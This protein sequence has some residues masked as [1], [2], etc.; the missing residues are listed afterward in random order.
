[1]RK[2]ADI[3]LVER[4]LAPSREKARALIK[5]GAVSLDNV[6]VS[7]PGQLIAPNASLTITGD[8]LRWAS[9]GALK[10]LAALEAF[11]QIDIKGRIAADIGASTGGFCDVL[12]SRNV[13][14]IY[15]V[16]VGHG[17]L[18]PKLA[19]HARITNLERTNARDITAT[20]IPDPLQ[21]ITCDVSFISVQKALPAVLSLAT[22]GCWLITLVK[23]QFEAGRAALG[24]SGVVKDEADRQRCLDEVS[25]FLSD[26]MRWQIEG[27]ITSP[28]I[29]P[30]GNNE[31]LLVARY[32]PA[33]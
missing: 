15:A 23:P 20:V 25:T 11:P 8:L 1:M 12:L 10:L 7:K 26:K 33:A 32:M 28:V 17:Q 19:R 6:P 2:R 4:G 14:H 30:E 9:R 22:S 29:G 5:D 13:Q 18:D 3:S 24:K 31:F 27:H 21:I 16:D